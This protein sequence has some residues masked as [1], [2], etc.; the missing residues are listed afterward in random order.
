MRQND[1]ERKPGPRNAEYSTFIDEI[2][3]RIGTGILS[4]NELIALAFDDISHT[5]T[6][7][8]RNYN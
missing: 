6:R 4:D 2:R 5:F 1:N 3:A 7:D 8:E